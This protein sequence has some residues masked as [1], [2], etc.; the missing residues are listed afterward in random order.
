MAWYCWYQN[1]PTVVKHAINHG[2]H[3]HV[4]HSKHAAA[5]FHKSLT[6]KVCVWT[7]VILGAGGLGGLVG[8]DI[9]KHQEVVVCCDV[10]HEAPGYPSVDIPKRYSTGSYPQIS[11]QYLPYPVFVHNWWKEYGNER[12]REYE[13]KYYR[14]DV[15]EPG[16]AFIFICAIVGLILLRI[17]RRD[18]I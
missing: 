7:G 5:I 10:R 3:N 13:R 9:A 8:N 11:R 16:S 17:D 12:D 18:N 14:K 4:V 1:I 15:D 6:A 2:P